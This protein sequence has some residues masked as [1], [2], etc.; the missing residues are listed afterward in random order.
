MIRFGNSTNYWIQSNDTFDI[1]RGAKR[2]YL[3]KSNNNRLA[4]DPD[5]TALVIT[6]MQNFF[7]SEKLGRKHKGIGLVNPIRKVI[8]HARMIG[9][10]IVWLNWGIRADMVNI[11]P[12]ISRIFYHA[13]T[14]IGKEL[15]NGLGLNLVKG[16]WSAEIIPE[17]KELV[18]L[19]DIQIEKNRVSGFFG[20]ELQQTLSN[21]DIKTLAFAG[22]N[23]DQ[24]VMGTLQD[25]HGYGYDCIL[26]EDCTATASPEFSFQSVIYN[27]NKMGFIT[28]SDYFCNGEFKYNEIDSWVNQQISFHS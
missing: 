22:I 21:L 27:V 15:P 23:T 5:R 7:L 14:E 17:L 24:C 16:S 28:N 25:A 20:T 3:L 26:L 9:M 11:P 18:E 4:F 13:G 8:K 1:S 10:K 6:D 2:K 19:E 12:G